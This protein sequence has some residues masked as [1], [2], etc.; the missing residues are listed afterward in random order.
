MSVFRDSVWLFLPFTHAFKLI[1]LLGL[2]PRKETLSVTYKAIVPVLIL[3][4]HTEIGTKGER[5]IFWVD[6]LSSERFLRCAFSVSRRMRC[7]MTV[8][9][10]LL[11][12][13]SFFI[14]SFP[15]NILTIFSQHLNSAPP[16]FFSFLSWGFH[17]KCCF[18][19][20]LTSYLLVL[21][22]CPF[23]WMAVSICQAKGDKSHT[24]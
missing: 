6:S 16:I 9:T 14:S 10:F 21:A 4:I 1:R 20:T 23:M 12:C 22:Y 18:L 8:H 17:L 15:P 7:S 11:L 3:I 2:T 24:A 19:W 5:A 13:W